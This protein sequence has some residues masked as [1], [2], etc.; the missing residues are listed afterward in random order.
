M[1]KSLEDKSFETLNSAA[2]SV[3]MRVRLASAAV[4]WAL[5]AQEWRT[6]YYEFTGAQA[7]RKGESSLQFKT[8]DDHHHDSLR[9]LIARHNIEQLWTEEEVFEISRVWH[10]LNGWPDSTSGLQALKDRGHVVCTLSNG[11]LR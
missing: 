6:S 9:A 2:S 3:G 11:N 4:D 10:F 5:F 8:V 7:S 1:T